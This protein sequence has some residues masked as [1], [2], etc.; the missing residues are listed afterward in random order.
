MASS[1][2][3]VTTA[4]ASEGSVSTEVVWEQK[5]KGAR[6]G[7]LVEFNHEDLELQYPLLRLKE[8]GCTVTLIGP[9]KDI[10][11]K[12]KHGYPCKADKYVF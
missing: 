3:E 8:E 1:A 9:R 5:L 12:G 7:I 2:E 11:F 6:V 4:A 10:T